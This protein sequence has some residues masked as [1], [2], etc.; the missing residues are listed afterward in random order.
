[1]KKYKYPKT[2]KLIKRLKPYYEQFKEIEDRYYKEIGDLER[3][4]EGV[5]GIKN[6]EFF[7]C[8]NECAGI[9][10]ADRTMELI[11]LEEIENGKI[12]KF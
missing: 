11:H 9:G 6:I 4:I 1:M 10:N 7:F 8:D 12:N 5:L 2:K 3:E